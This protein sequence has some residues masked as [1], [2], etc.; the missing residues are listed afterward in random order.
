MAKKGMEEEYLIEKT[1]KKVKPTVG[2]ETQELPKFTPI[3]EAQSFELVEDQIPDADSNVEDDEP[4]LEVLPSEPD[5]ELPS[6]P[7]HYATKPFS[8]YLFGMLFSFKENEIIAD[9]QKILEL[10]KLAQP[11]APLAG[12][13]QCPKCKHIFAG[14]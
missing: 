8:C 14:G 3:L 6:M 13:H 12:Q 4:I 2:E 11:I 1:L 7:A 5:A 10:T 9:G